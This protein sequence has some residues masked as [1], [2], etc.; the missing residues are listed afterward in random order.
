MRKVYY[1]NYRN[2]LPS[3]QFRLLKSIAVEDGILQPT[4]GNF[5]SRNE[6]TSASSVST[7]LKALADKEMTVLIA[8]NGRSMMCSSQD[9]L[10]II[11]K[12]DPSLKGTGCIMIFRGGLTRNNP[13]S[14]L[15]HQFF[16]QTVFALLFQIFIFFFTKRILNFY[17]LWCNIFF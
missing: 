12:I 9:G 3:H 10:S 5:I 2:L 6:L 14:H 7:S 15:R 17:S 8:T 1:V 16:N 13:L 4:S 11:I